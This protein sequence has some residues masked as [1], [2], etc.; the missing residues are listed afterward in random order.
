[1]DLMKKLWSLIRRKKKE[2]PFSFKEDILKRYG[3]KEEKDGKEDN[4]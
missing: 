2:K 3:K 1:M 4:T